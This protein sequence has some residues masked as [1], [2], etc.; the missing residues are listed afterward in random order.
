MA[1]PTGDL[2]RGVAADGTGAGPRV[3]GV[4]VVRADVGLGVLVVDDSQEEQLPAR[5]QHPVRRRVL[6]GRRHRKSVAIPRDHRRRIAFRFAVERRRLVLGHVLTVRVFHYAR[7]TDRART[8]NGPLL[9]YT[10]PT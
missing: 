4:A 3:G 6:V 7:V 5:Q 1:P 2:Q 9:Y 8:C 10:W